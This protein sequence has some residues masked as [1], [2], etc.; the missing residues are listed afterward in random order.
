MIDLAKV[1]SE[2]YRSLSP[3]RVFMIGALWASEKHLLH[4]CWIACSAL[5]SSVNSLTS[6]STTCCT[7]STLGLCGSFTILLIRYH[8]HF[9]SSRLILC[10]IFATLLCCLFV[11]ASIKHSCRCTFQSPFACCCNSA[12]W[13]R[14]NCRPS[15]SSSIVSWSG[16]LICCCQANWRIFP[17]FF[18]FPS[19]ILISCK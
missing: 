12:F 7:L 6:P 13:M 8:M 17:M 19:F 15:L 10:L 1:S 11:W 4:L 5:S 3:R 16:C 9:L 14:A 18:S 2:R